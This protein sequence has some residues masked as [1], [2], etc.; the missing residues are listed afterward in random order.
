MKNRVCVFFF[1][2]KIFAAFTNVINELEFMFTL[3]SGWNYFRYNFAE[4]IR[5]VFS[6]NIKIVSYHFL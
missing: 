3:I 1:G 5:K 2:R 6:T 4:I